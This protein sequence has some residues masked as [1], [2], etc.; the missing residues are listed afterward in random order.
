MRGKSILQLLNGL[1]GFGIFKLESAI[2]KISQH[3]SSK[4]LSF[5]QL[6]SLMLSLR[7]QASPASPF[8]HHLEWLP[9]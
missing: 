4:V 9:A 8:Q 3:V 6:F 1:V 5:E 7:E 2:N